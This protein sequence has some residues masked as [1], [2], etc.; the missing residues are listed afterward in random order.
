[1]ASGPTFGFFRFNI[2]SGIERILKRLDTD[3]LDVFQIFWEGTTS[4]LS[5]AV[6][7]AMLKLK[8]EGK[9]RHLGISIHDRERA[10]QLAEDSALDLLMIRYNAAH[11]GAER[12]IFPH[13]AR[14]Q[15]AVVAYTATRWGKLLRRPRG[16]E[17][18]VPTAADCYRF[19]L[20]NPHVDVTLCGPKSLLQ[21]DEN[22]AGLQRG[23]MDADELRWIRD[24]GKVV[25]G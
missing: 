6:L 20:S 7:E 3:Y 21:L 15:P 13:L 1:M 23:P 14:R 10:G 12:D 22:L 25:H 17:G 4:R 2:Q 19:C 9:V 18:P 5:P 16:W 8:D 24:F 11:P